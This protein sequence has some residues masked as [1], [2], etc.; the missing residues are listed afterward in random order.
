MIAGRQPREE[1]GPPL[2]AGKR[3]TLVV[4]A[5]W[6]DEDGQPLKAAFRKSFSVGK[7]DDVQP[8]PKTWKLHAPTAGNRDPLRVQFPESLD[9]ALLQRMI[10]VV[11]AAGKKIAGAVRVSRE[12]SVWEF[13]PKKPWAAGA[14]RLTVD[15]ALEDLAGNSVASPFEVVE[16]RPAPKPVGKTVELPFTVR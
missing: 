10:W 6:P 4:D 16:G 12:E 11:D 2:E 9:H 7:P 14:Y 8:D 15:T 3:Y 1:L 13:I 5:A